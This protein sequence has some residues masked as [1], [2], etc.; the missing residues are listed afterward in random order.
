MDKQTYV[1]Q[2]SSLHR[3]VDPESSVW[4]RG[5][6]AVVYQVVK[7]ADRTRLSP[8]TVTIF[9][10]AIANALI[11]WAALEKRFTLV[12]LFVVLSLLVDALDGAIA[13]AKNAAT[14]FGGVLDS[15]FDRINELALVAA[16]VLASDGA[17]L[18]PAVSGLAVTFILEYARAKAASLPISAPERITVWERPTRT[19]VTASLFIVAAAMPLADVSARDGLMLG[20]WAW[21]TLA[22]IGL[23]QMMRHLKPYLARSTS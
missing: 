2:W 3:G 16:L 13:V 17:A 14:A 18:L 19:V 6:L 10:G 15:V 22:L 5:Y 8:N 23:I 12:A 1:A 9:G 11:V 20:A 21:P 7:V 4:V